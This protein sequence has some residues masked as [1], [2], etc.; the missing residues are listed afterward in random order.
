[1]PYSGLLHP[2]DS[3]GW[4]PWEPSPQGQL[5]HIVTLD[6]Q[7]HLTL[8]HVL[9]VDTEAQRREVV[10]LTPHSR[11]WLSSVHNYITFV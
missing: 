4:V 9:G 8:I 10:C 2:G 5:P 1:M 3:Q 7:G 11:W 6:P